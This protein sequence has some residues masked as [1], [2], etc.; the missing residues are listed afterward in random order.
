MSLAR[1]WRR[2][3]FAASGAA[4]IVPCAMLGALMVLALGGGFSQLG[5]LRQIF[6]G[7]PA[8]SGGPVVAAHGGSA[9]ASGALPVIPVVRTFA[10]RPT[11]PTG[12]VHHSV[13]LAPS[14]GTGKSG[15]AVTP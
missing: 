4:V 12:P 1:I 10:R 2:Q 9:P 15:G 7:P 13:G 14:A 8:P 3:L 5:V 11:V 6:V